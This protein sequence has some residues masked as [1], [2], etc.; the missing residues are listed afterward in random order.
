MK[1][2]HCGSCEEMKLGVH[3]TSLGLALL[4]GAYNAAAWLALPER[5]LDGPEQ[6]DERDRD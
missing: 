4:C 6:T 1:V 3:A 2:L 5:A